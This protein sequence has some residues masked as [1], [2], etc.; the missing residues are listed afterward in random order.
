MVR[1][2]VFGAF[3]ATCALLAIVLGNASSAQSPSPGPRAQSASDPIY[4]E[5]FTSQGCSSCPP[6]D[7]LAE[8][9]AQEEGVVIISRP[10]DYWDR[11]GWKDTLA[12]P[13]NT[14]LQRAYARRGLDGYNGVYTP[15]TV[16]AGTYGEVGSDERSL[17][18]QI[19]EA[20]SDPSRAR[21]RVQS[22]GEQ[23]FAIGL[24]GATGTPAEL[25][26][27]GVSSVEDIS[28]ARG[29]NRGR[30]VRYTNALIGERRVAT[31]NGGVNGVAVTKDQLRMAGADRYAVVLREANGGRVLA[32]QW[33]R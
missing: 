28:I 20:Q 4:I 17:R 27:L 15:Q 32:A 2:L 31:W 30:T 24:A 18:R 11:L 16:V 22:A 3:A 9:L 29:E 1:P 5:L 14:A 19:R 10:V 23:G 6:A 33:L 21:L 25:I 13:A 7:R 12:S 8:K 26:L